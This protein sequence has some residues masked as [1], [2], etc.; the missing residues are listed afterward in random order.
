[1]QGLTQKQRSILDFIKEHHKTHQMIPSYRTI[2]RFFAYASVSTVARHITALKKKGY[3]PLKS[4]PSDDTQ[5]VLIIGRFAENQ[6]LELLPHSTATITIAKIEQS[7]IY[8]F[9]IADSSLS[10]VG[11]L[12]QD[13]LIVHATSEIHENKLAF[14][15][16][17]GK[18]TLR[19][20]TSEGPY[21]R[22]TSP[23]DQSSLLLPRTQLVPR[24]YLCQSI[25]F[26]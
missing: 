4:T 24:A 13:I 14:I 8:A 20:I 12:P 3:L 18:T 1:M 6:P 19:N 21:L 5:S 15:E 23:L 16:I 11:L 7:P 26:F 9:E 22:V 25:R 17:N 2:M 10:A